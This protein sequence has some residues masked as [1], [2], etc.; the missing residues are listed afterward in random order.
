MDLAALYDM[1]SCNDAHLAV[2]SFDGVFDY[3][4]MTPYH[5]VPFAL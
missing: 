2:F 4:I 3:H 5:P 1:W